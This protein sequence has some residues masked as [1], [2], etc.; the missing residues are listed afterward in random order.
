M[1]LKTLD[2][3]EVENGDWAWYITVNRDSPRVVRN[4][5]EFPF[6]GL[7]TVACYSTEQAALYALRVQI[8]D[9]IGDAEA[10]IRRL[11]AQRQTVWNR[12]VSLENKEA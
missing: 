4:L 11:E 5:V 7:P 2:G 3:V 10:S 8:D 6:D 9:A 12:L 1:K